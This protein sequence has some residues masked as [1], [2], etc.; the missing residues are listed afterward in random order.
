MRIAEMLY[1]MASWLESPNNE[2][3]QLSEYDEQ[4]L[5][6][7]AESCVNAASI[8]KKAAEEVSILEPGIESEITPDNLD[9]LASLATTFDASGDL[10]LRKMASVIDEMILTIAAPK[11]AFAERKDLLEN[12]LVELKKKYEDPQ[13]ELQK[14][15][16]VSDSEKAID[17]SKMNKEFKINEHGLSS[18]YCPDHPGCQIARV[19]E[20]MWQCSMDLRVYSFDTGFSLLNGEHVPGGDVSLQT[21]IMQADDYQAVFDDRNGRLSR[22]Q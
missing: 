22:N 19:G 8:L 2:A 20:H 17:K 1:T 11:N 10:E 18:R 7:V 21:K 15:N 16:K 12:R 13:K 5:R 14:L 6:V 9:N 4:C 3:I